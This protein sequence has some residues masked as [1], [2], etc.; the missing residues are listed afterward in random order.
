M[1]NQSISSKHLFTEL[2]PIRVATLPRLSAFR[3]DTGTSNASRLGWKVAYRMQRLLTGHWIWTQNRLVTDVQIDDDKVQETLEA[4]WQSKTI[5]FGHIRQIQRDIQWQHTPLNIAEFAANGL[6]SDLDSVIKNQLKQHHRKIRNGYV[7][8]D[9]Y[10]RGWQFNDKPVVSI[11]ISSSVYSNYVLANLARTIGD[12]SRLLNLFVRDVT[13][14]YKGEIV[15]I[16]GSLAEHRDR[17]LKWTTRD[18]MR[19]RIERAPNDDLVLKVKNAFNDGYDY[20]SSALQLVV[21]TKD[22]ER[23]NINAQ[24]ALSV[25]QLKPQ[26]RADIVQEIAE[27]IANAGYIRSQPISATQFASNFIVANDIDFAPSARLGND[28]ICKADVRT[29]LRALRENPVYRRSAELIGKPIRIGVLNLIGDHPLGRQY[30]GAIREELRSINFEVEFTTVARATPQSQFE[31]EKAIDSLA[32]DNPHIIMGILPASPHNNE[33][34]RS[35]SLYSQL[36]SY[37]LK[38]DLQSQFVDETTLGNQYALSNIILGIIGKIGNVPYVLAERLSYADIVAGIDVARIP[39]VRRSGS[40]NI[41]AVTRVYTAEGDFLRYILSDGPIEGETLSKNILRQLFP[42]RYF[43]DKRAVIHR[44]GP[45]RGAE[46]QHLYEWAEEIG[47]TFYLIEVIKSGVPRLYAVRSTVERPQK[48]S[49]LI[50]SDEEAFLVS[51]LSPHKNSTPRPLLI[52]TDSNLS[53]EHALHSVL[54]MTILHY[55]SILQ[56]RLP[57]TIHYSDKIGYLALQGVKPSD[58]EGTKPYWL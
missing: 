53:I 3:L 48:G 38:H 16:I 12:T 23:L 6:L 7:E 20:I 37:L 9:Y 13:S 40:I 27:I 19:Q 28:H 41:P 21:R 5:D 45:W 57:I 50:L 56:P 35:D 1:A 2:Y 15:E 25:L 42:A 33:D 36:K 54:S 14:D 34:D 47:G 55:G 51:S 32:E 52:R 31:L 17:L 49:A 29:I 10:I 39:T 22:Y 24:E 26:Y 30:L 58:T 46:K 43:A 11:S 18:N 44:D 8:R 4:L